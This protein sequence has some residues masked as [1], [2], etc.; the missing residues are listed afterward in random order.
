MNS[1]CSWWKRAMYCRTIIN[2]VQ[3]NILKKHIIV[4][5]VD[6][7]TDFQEQLRGTEIKTPLSATAT[8]FWEDQS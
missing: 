7:S 4:S 1:G 3:P 8:Q 5:K 6:H 2:F